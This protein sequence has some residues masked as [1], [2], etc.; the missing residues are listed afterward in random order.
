MT[1]TELL[2][3]SPLGWRLRKCGEV[4]LATDL[5][6]DG[7]VWKPVRDW[8]VGQTVDGCCYRSDGSPDF[9]MGRRKRRARK[10]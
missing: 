3:Q 8:L 7:P 5:E 6:P 9:I 2:A 1:Y 10:T 4:I